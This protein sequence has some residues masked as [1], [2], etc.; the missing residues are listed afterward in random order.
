MYAQ[1]DVDRN[2]YLLLECFVDAQ[3]DNTTI[4]LDPQKSVHNG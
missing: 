1:C 4:S 2:K 3:K